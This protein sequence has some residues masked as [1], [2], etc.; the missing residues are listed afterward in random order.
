VSAKED[1]GAFMLMRR[2]ALDMVGLF[3]DGYWM[4]I[5]DLDL[6][7][8]FKQARSVVWYEPSRDGDPRQGR[9]EWRVP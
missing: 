1:N 8:R 6:C 4:C 7:Y 5:D 2:S 9:N 3:D